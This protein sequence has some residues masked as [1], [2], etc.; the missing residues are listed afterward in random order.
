MNVPDLNRDLYA[1]INL[2]DRTV[3]NQTAQI[4]EKAFD[5]IQ[6]CQTNEE[7]MKWLEVEA[8]RFLK[9]NIF[10]DPPEERDFLN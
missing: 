5:G 10:T 8:K 6:F 1:T 4:F 3:R 9:R 2:N 7:Y